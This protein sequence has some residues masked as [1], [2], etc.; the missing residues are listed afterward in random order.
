MCLLELDD[1]NARFDSGPCGAHK[2][3]PKPVSVAPDLERE[4]VPVY[5]PVALPTVAE[6]VVKPTV[7]DVDNDAYDDSPDWMRGAA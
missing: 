3:I 7:P 4:R 2:A 6:L 1:N 5:A